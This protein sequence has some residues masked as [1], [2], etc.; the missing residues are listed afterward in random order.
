MKLA[1]EIPSEQFVMI[2]QKAKGDQKYEELLRLAADAHNLKFIEY[3]PF[4]EIDGYFQRAKVFVNTSQA[5]GFPSTFVQ[6]GKNATAIVSLKVNPD[7]FLDKFN[8]GLCADDDWNKFVDC[9]KFVL[10]EDKYIELGKN[11]RKYVEDNH[12]IAKIIEIYKQ[13][14]IDAAAKSAG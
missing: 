1:K 7:G 5:E 9:L 13:H 11:A 8:C 12:D 3:V 2:C 14:F 4:H 10:S 6:A